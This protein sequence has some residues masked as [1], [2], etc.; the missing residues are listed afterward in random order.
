MYRAD[1]IVACATA[2]GRGAIAVVRLSGR[3]AFPI[4]DRIVQLASPAP[5]ARLLHR[6]TARDVPS[7][8]PID[9][10]LAVRMPGPGTYTGEDTLEIYCHGSPIVV[11]QIVA[12]ATRAGAR[13]AERGEFTRRA[14][15]NGRMD[16]LQAEAVADLIDARGAGGAALA[17]AQLQG[18]LS[19]R[20]SDLRSRI[21]AVVADVEANVDFSED[22]L[23][24]ENVAARIDALD[25]VIADIGAMLADF[26]AGRRWREG[27]R[28]V[29][30]GRP[31]VGKSSLL[32]ALLGHPRMI[33]SD[34]PG[35]TRDSVEEGVEVDGAQLV[36]V[37]TAGDRE[38]PGDA[39]RQ[40][41]ARARVQAASADVLVLVVD[42]SVALTAEDRRLLAA[43]DGRERIV[44]VNKGD[45]PAVLDRE[46]LR[47]HAG[48]GVT[49]LD[50]AALTG[51]GCPALSDE[52]RRRAAN[53]APA[54]AAAISR[55]R[56][57]TALENARKALL[58]AGE[59]LRADG[60]AELVSIELRT[61]LAELASIT[62]P[63][64]N[65]EVLDVIFREFCIGK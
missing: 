22:E 29:F 53:A 42:G 18:A 59:L 54:E 46:E 62:D 19:R 47:V 1:T 34:E 52:L 25:A 40:A 26:A 2:P 56:H 63:V 50:V 12:A 60:A 14:V 21:V 16:L 27:H 7:G 64:D 10:V 48:E 11:E 61:A 13:V 38:T 23:P 65:D 44:A 3:E 5:L 30:A 39:E 43:A 24:A 8:S 20:I 4:A 35:T 33:V 58:A 36:L 31:N 32:N 51:A 49:I 6:G 17:W 37:D 55:V 57:R 45:L 28:V 9:E 41:I 15:L